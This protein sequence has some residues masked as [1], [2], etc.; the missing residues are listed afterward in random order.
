MP[1]KRKK[2]ETGWAF[3]RSAIKVV[4]KTYSSVEEGR[5]KVIPSLLERNS[6]AKVCELGCAWGDT[7]VQ[8]AQIM[9]TTQMYGVDCEQRSLNGA[10]QRGVK[11]FLCDL[12]N[13]LPFDN[14]TFD[15]IIASHV[16]EHLQ[17]TDLFCK[18]MHR[19][20][21]RGG[22]TII[23][24]PNLAA[25]HEIAALV[26]GLQPF[27]AHVSDETFGLGNRFDPKHGVKHQATESSHLRCFTL[28]ALRDL[29]QYH[30]F[31]VEKIVGVGYYP[32][33]VKIARI[34]SRIDSRHAAILIMKAC[35]V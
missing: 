11:T 23:A 32:F 8:A 6:Q 33:P 22:Y 4:K 17:K 28:G 2:I 21:K 25:T 13:P 7:L 19:C 34:L 31:K 10:S 1:D 14:E 30:G 18:E 26:L 27:T 16:I 12:N 3:L 29:L 5:Y 15:V 24:T 35:K 9:G 20:L